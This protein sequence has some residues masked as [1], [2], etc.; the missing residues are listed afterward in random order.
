MFW[1]AVAITLSVL[2]LAGKAKQFASVP[3]ILAN[4]TLVPGYFK[5]PF[6]DGV[7]WTL[8][9]ELKFYLIVAFAILLGQMKR[10]ELWMY[11]W[12]AGLIAATFIESVPLLK[13]LTM[14]P[15]GFLFVGGAVAYFIRSRGFSFTRGAALF[16]CT[17]FSVYHAIQ[18]L[19]DFTFAGALASALGV[20]VLVVGFHVVLFLISMKWVRL[21]SAKLLLSLGALTYPLYLLHNVIGKVVFAW[22]QPQYGMWPGL[23]AILVVA[24][25]LSWF[26]AARVEPLVRGWVASL[27]AKATRAQPSKLAVTTKHG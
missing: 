2:V 15:H 21:P 17:V 16:L 24:Y 11:V 27:I 8:A 7:Y 19:T 18:G 20:A 25:G 9:I 12:L 3:V 10:I 5:V 22:I 23:C 14:L 1:V 6:V 26:C 4:L 13:S